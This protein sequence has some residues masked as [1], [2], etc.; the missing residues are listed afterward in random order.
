[1]AKSALLRHTTCCAM[2]S[3]FIL[4]VA[5]KWR[6]LCHATMADLILLQFCH[7]LVP[8]FISTKLLVCR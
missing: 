6:M 1:M 8:I 5:C 7:G 3:A 4:I 2:V